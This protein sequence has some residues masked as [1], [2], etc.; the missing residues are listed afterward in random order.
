MRIYED[1]LNLA[2]ADIDRI[3]DDM[4]DAFVNNISYNIIRQYARYAVGTEIEYPDFEI[5]GYDGYVEDAV[6][7]IIGCLG[8]SWENAEEQ[9]IV[10][11]I[12][13]I[14][15]ELGVD[16]LSDYE[17]TEAGVEYAQE[18]YKEEYERAYEEYLERRYENY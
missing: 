18:R 6:H 8:D 14:M 13:K 9:I 3:T 1:I 4:A 2:Y 7:A 12:A 5:L 16:F 11:N 10:D 15:F 17:Y